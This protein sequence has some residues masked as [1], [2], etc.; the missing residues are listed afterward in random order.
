M[1]SAQSVA[2]ETC[3]EP[4]RVIDISPVAGPLRFVGLG[5]YVLLVISIQEVLACVEI[6]V[7]DWK[8][9]AILLAALVG[10]LIF[11]LGRLEEYRGSEFRSLQ[12]NALGIFTNM[13]GRRVSLYH[14]SV[15]RVRGTRF[16]F[17]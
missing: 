11:C 16:D 3:S 10:L 8:Q 15:G 9:P 14:S 12:Q 2:Q 6:L 5:R 13:F 4:L 1:A 7:T 17:R